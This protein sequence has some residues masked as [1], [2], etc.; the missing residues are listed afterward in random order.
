MIFFSK[1]R[2]FSCFFQLFYD[3]AATKQDMI[4]KINRNH[5]TIISNHFGKS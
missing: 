4:L 1:Y 3:L 5:L 2:N